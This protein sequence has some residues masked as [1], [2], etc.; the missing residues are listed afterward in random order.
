M[1]MRPLTTSIPK[2]MVE[3]AGKSLIHRMLEQLARSG[4]TEAVVNLSHMA[5]QLEPHLKPVQKPKL[6]FSFEEEPLETGGGIAKALP[7]LGDKPFFSTN[8]DVIYL[9][10]VTPALHRLAQG[11]ETDAVPNRGRY[12]DHPAR[13]EDGTAYAVAPRGSAPT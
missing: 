4:I 8:S 6:T 12:I 10:G 1:R 5:E 2:P 9:D 11:F 3:V 7:L 13:A